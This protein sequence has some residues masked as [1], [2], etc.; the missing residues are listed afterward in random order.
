M[1]GPLKVGV[2]GGGQRGLQH[3]EYLVRLQADDEVRLVALA[4]PQPENLE[5]GSIQTRA[6]TYR[7]GETKLY[8]SAH[9]ML[10]EAEIDAVWFVIPPNLH[11]GETQLA[12]GRAIAIFAEKPQ[13]LFYDEAAQQ[14]KTIRDAGVISTAGFQMRYGPWYVALSDY[15]ADRAVTSI[16]MVDGGGEELGGPQNRIWTAN[17]AWSGSSVVEAGIDQT[18]LM[19]YWTHDEIDW[20][21]AAYVERDHSL[22]DVEGDNLS[23]YTVVYGFKRGAVANLIFT[24]PGRVYLNKRYDYILTTHSQVKFEDE[25]VAYGY[26]GHEYPPTERPTAEDVRQVL[27]S[28]PHPNPMGD[29]NSLELDRKF[30]EAVTQNRPEFLKNT[31]E[32]SLN[33]LAAVLAANV[34]HEL[35]GERTYLE[36][37]TTGD[38]FTR[39]R[40]RPDGQ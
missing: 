26:H 15:T 11:K 38:R 22:H 39:Y 29:E 12:T 18:D 6:S 17:P 25:L 32:S 9:Q 1:P 13:T 28:G 3:V 33:S 36:E 35:K 14:A 23:A 30:A 21:Q 27:A 40:N 19:R 16:T 34:S 5:E 7:Q 2:I 20:V 24:R 31:F 10:Q 37:F 4:D 8:G